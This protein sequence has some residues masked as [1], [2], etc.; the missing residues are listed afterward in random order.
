MLDVLSLD[1]LEPLARA[2][3]SKMAYDYIAGGSDSEWTLKENRAA[4]GRLQLVP[5]VLVDVSERSLETTV[6][7]ASFSLPV[8][9]APMAFHGLV[10][11][12]GE[13]ATARGAGAAGTIMVASTLSNRSLEEIAAA[14]AGAGWFQLYVYRDRG[15]TRSL[16]E[17][18][19]A[20]GYGALCVTVDAPLIGRRFRD[21]RNEFSLPANLQL[22]NFA[23]TP[24]DDLPEAARESGL[25]AYVASQWDPGLTWKDIDWLRSLSS[26]PL[27]LKGIMS[28]ADARLAVEHGAGAIVV[29]NHGGRQLDT[30]PAAITVLPHIA[31][32]VDGRI[33]ILV[34]GG[35]RRGTDVLK[36]L[37]LGARAVMLG[38]PIFW[39][40]ALDGEAGVKAVLDLLRV[41]L[42]MALALAGCKS[43]GEAT[44]ELILG[45][46]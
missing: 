14:S 42:D 25:A 1:D 26:L 11:P 21:M 30:A 5:R 8:L 36:A 19:A 10:H 43:V 22:A 46:S 3:L 9:V 44:P 20:A 40:L 41:E 32:A 7:G 15:L 35:I 13:V 39:G 34:D 17:R 2:A 4:F 18:A 31:T 45:R 38:R 29:S 28:T 24:I 37:A 16:V 12:D 23:D 33:E 27:V 6:L